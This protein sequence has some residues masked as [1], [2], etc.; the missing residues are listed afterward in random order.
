M[1]IAFIN[2]GQA[3]MVTGQFRLFHGQIQMHSYRSTG[4]GFTL[5]E[6]M[7]IISIIVVLATIA[8]PAFQNFRIRAKVAEGLSVTEPAMAAISEACR[9]KPTRSIASVA[10]LGYEFSPT[11]YASDLEFT[12][13]D[14]CA[15]PVQLVLYTRN[16]GAATDVNLTLL[17]TYDARTGDIDWDCRILAG[18]ALHAPEDCRDPWPAP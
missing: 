11:K 18:E 17:G 15:D 4:R 16:T 9:S 8:V 12:F 14:S 10:D 13:G 3:R 6:L 5:I 2:Q 1:E 7:I